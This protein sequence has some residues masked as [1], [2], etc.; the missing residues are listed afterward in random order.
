ML[1]LSRRVGERV[2]LSN[3]VVVKVLAIRGHQA[4]LGFEAPEDVAIRR[5]ELAWTEWDHYGAGTSDE[6]LPQMSA[7]Q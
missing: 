1:V 4:R 6:P 2:I 3:G 5:E 7:S